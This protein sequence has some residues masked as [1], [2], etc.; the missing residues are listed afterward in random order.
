MADD[1]SELNLLG[2]A[3]SIRKDLQDVATSVAELKSVPRQIESLATDV[4][5]LTRSV[6]GLESWRSHFERHNLVERL[7]QVEDAIKNPPSD[8]FMSQDELADHRRQR[9]SRFLLRDNLPLT[10]IATIP[11]ILSILF[12]VYLAIHGA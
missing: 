3:L 11:P 2:V 10:L 5:A 12:S 6:D 8:R 9:N 4:K 7:T 1:H